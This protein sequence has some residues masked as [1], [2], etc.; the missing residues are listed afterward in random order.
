MQKSYGIEESKGVEMTKER[1]IEILKDLLIQL[2]DSANILCTCEADE[3]CEA[4]EECIK[5]LEQPTSDDVM[6]IHTQGLAEGIRC[7]M[8][9][10]S[11]KSDRNCD[12]GCVVDEDMYKKVMETINNQMFSQPTS[13]DC[14]SR[15]AVLDKAELIE[16]ED[17]QTFYCISP[18]DI[19][20]L[21]PVT[22][23]H[24]I[25]K[26]CENWDKDIKQCDNMCWCK[27]HKGFYSANYFCADFA[28][29]GNEN[30][31]N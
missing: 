20:A 5:T 15:Q 1:K 19:K 24:G 9:T 22:P 23:T 7:A 21:P 3:R 30:G 28:K 11:M 29:R 25:C 18:E 27:V 14:V 4:V 10:N 31:S 12:G 13:D 26:D 16:L 6:A 17:G 8:C 2:S